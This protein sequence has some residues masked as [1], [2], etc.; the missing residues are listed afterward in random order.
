MHKAQ[1]KS[2]TLCL[3]IIVLAG[4]CVTAGTQPTPRSS[5]RRKGGAPRCPSQPRGHQR[6]GGG[7]LAMSARENQCQGSSGEHSKHEGSIHSG[8]GIGGSR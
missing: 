4:M 8:T 5:E 3:S 7:A 6:S 1:L 2:P